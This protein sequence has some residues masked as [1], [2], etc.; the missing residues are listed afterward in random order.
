MNNA[1]FPIDA[2]VATDALARSMRY[3]GIEDTIKSLGGLTK[4]EK[5]CLQMGVPETG[6]P[7]LDDIIR[8][9]NKQKASIAIMK[10][11]FSGDFMDIRDMADHARSLA[12]ELLKE[13]NK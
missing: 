12:N 9:G 8:K 3:E 1:D 5:F 7:E 2:L 11:L 10:G 4:R 13:I 6:D